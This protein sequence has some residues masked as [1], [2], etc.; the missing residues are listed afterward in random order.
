MAFTF[1]KAL[2]RETGQS[3]VEDDLVPTAKQ[4]LAEA[5]EHGVD[6]LHPED[7]MMALYP[8][9]PGPA[10]RCRVDEIPIA[11]T[12]LDIGPTTLTRFRERL[13]DAA[14]VIWNGPVGMCEL[15]AFAHGT[16]EMAKMVADVTGLTVAAGRDTAAAVRR[17]GVADRI[18]YVSTAG[19][20]FLEALE[21]RELPGVAALSPV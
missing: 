14:T 16:V 12:G 4:I 10:K 3:M 13:R 2:G 1:L 8:E 6:V 18:T 9:Q 11:M 20:A 15:P 21:G 7:L 17:A 5:T 19:A